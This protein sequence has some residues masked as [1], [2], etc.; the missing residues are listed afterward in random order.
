MIIKK[1]TGHGGYINL[2]AIRDYNRKPSEARLPA[3]IEVW[4]KSV[5]I[6]FPTHGFM[7]IVIADYL[8]RFFRLVAS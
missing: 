2:I 4:L 7:P 3:L 8:I 6:W 1:A 5:I